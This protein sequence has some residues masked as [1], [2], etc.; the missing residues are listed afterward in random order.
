[1]RLTKK[2]IGQLFDCRGGDGSYVLRLCDV[3]R[4]VLLFYSFSGYYCIDSAKS[5][6][7]RRYDPDQW[8]SDWTKEGWAN[9]KYDCRKGE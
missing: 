1:M 7:Y 4:G 8:D 3:K 9:Y 2:N 5:T 6:D